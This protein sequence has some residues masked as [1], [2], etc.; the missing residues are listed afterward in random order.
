[1]RQT[2]TGRMVDS[3]CQKQ[4]GHL[5][6]VCY[7]CLVCC[8][9]TPVFTHASHTWR[10]RFGFSNWPLHIQTS[11]QLC[12]L[13][14]AGEAIIFLLQTESSFPVIAIYIVGQNLHLHF[15]RSAKIGSRIEAKTR[16]LAV[17]GGQ[18]KQ[19]CILY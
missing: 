15:L 4:M 3:C 16:L 7:I 6:K 14:R 5:E 1:M 13:C 12:A 19:R 18:I 8:V 11:V 10:I 2:T 17:R 9:K